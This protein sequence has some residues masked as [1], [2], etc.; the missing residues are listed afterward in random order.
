MKIA[1]FSKFSTNKKLIDW[2]KEIYDLCSPKDLHLCDGSDEEF[3]KLI[4]SLEKENKVIRLNPKKRPNSYYFRTNSDDVARVEEATFICTEKKEDVGPTNNWKDPKEMKAHLNELFKGS[5]KGRT[6][7][8]IPFSMGPLGSDKSILGVQI[9]DSEYVVCNMKM[10]TRMGKEPLKLIDKNDFVPCLHSVGVPLNEGEKDALWPCNVEKRCIVHFPHERR[11][12]SFGSGYGGNALLGKKCLSLRIG[13]H[14]AKEEGWL[15]EHMLILSLT[16]P[17]GEKKY[18]AAAFPSACGKTNLAMMKSALKDWS[19][20]CIGDDIAW[21]K[22]GKDGKL[23]AINPEAGFFGVAPGTS[24]KSNPH[25]MKCIEKDTIFTN[26][27]LTE[28]KDVWWEG[29]GIE[30]KNITSWLGEKIQNINEKKAAHPNSRFTTSAK[31]CPVIAKEWEDP[32]G[33]PISAIIFGGR[34]DDTV[35]LVFEAFDWNHGVFLGSS[36]TSQMTAAAKGEIG[37]L[38]YD[39]FAMLPFCGYNMGD[40]FAHWLKMGKETSLENLPKIFYVNWFKKDESGFLWPGYGDNIR[41]LKWIFQRIKGSIDG[42][43]TP[44]GLMPEWYDLDLSN[45]SIS[46]EKLNK[47]FEVDLEKWLHEADQLEQFFKIF[48]DRMPKEL[49]NQLEMLKERLNESANSKSEECP[50]CCRR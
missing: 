42:V 5:M 46:F 44:L 22:F 6:M 23:Y 10:M 33:V 34:R 36:I 18:I 9:T 47:L 19:V 29:I 39:P 37:K 7:Y 48:K 13:S 25:A 2:V 50:C 16:N 31:N 15:A 17:H 28:D 12:I 41:I 45:L 32:K 26:T 3:Q 8:V 40:Y 49:L 43:K 1:D 4:S 24:E 20:E 27:A 30:E 11:I 38:R 35:P 21:M 14:I